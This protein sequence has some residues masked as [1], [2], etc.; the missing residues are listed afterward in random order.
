MLRE[1]EHRSIAPIPYWEFA[2]LRYLVPRQRRCMDALAIIS[3]TLDE[4][5]AKCKQL[6]RAVAVSPSIVAFK[7]TKG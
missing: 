2:P 7:I 6:V 5:I 4:L 3:D 1:A